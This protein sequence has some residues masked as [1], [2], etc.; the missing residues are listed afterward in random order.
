MGNKN[1]LVTIGIPT[2]NRSDMLVRAV[3]SA[4]D[5]SHKNL[6]VVVC[7]NASEPSAQRVLEPFLG[8]PRLRYCYFEERLGLDQNWNRCLHLA[9]GDFWLCLS[10]DDWIE[11]NAISEMVAAS[12]PDVGIVLCSYFV[13]T[14][15]GVFIKNMPADGVI[16]GRNF[17]ADRLAGRSGYP[18]SEMFR[19]DLVLKCGGYHNIGYAMDLM[20]ELDVGALAKVAY[21][22]MPLAHHNN[23][24]EMASLAQPIKTMTTL[25]KLAKL[26]PERYEED[27]FSEIREYCIR[28][29]YGRTIDGALNRNRE[30]TQTGCDG[31]KALAAPCRVQLNASL[32]NIPIVQ[33]SLHSL[34]RAKRRIIGRFV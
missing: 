29:L 16:S 18:T 28:G 4:L 30:Q 3:K 19:L 26:A 22:D 25:V 7:D 8:D 23:H 12:E 21:V 14:D 31:L 13:H 10:D 2:L 33:W 11:P 5:Q 24:T 32:L 1:P 15:K 34:R 27:I 17:I 20:L 9:K 6:E